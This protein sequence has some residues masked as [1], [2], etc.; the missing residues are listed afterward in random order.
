MEAAF[1]GLIIIF[2]LH[3]IIILTFFSFSLSFQSLRLECFFKNATT[4]PYNHQK[5]SLEVATLEQFSVKL[6]QQFDSAQHLCYMK[7]KSLFDGKTLA[8][9]LKGNDSVAWQFEL[10]YKAQGYYWQTFIYIILLIGLR[11]NY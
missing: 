2:V 3:A 4:E 5:V 8:V 6:H 10:P 9:L 1:T 11:W 7:S